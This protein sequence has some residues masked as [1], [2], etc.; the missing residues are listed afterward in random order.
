MLTPPVLKFPDDVRRDLNGHRAGFADEFEQSLV[1]RALPCV[2]VTATRV[3]D[4]PLRRNSVARLFGANAA[5]ALLGPTESKFGGI[6][7]SEVE[8]DWRGYRFLGQINLT[9]A[10]AVLPSR[11]PKLDGL[12][13]IDRSLEG[14]ITD[15]IRVRWFPNI[16]SSRAVHATPESVG[17]W[18]TR[19]GFKLS[20]T[21]PEGNALEALWPL[22]DGPQW[23]YYDRFF[24]AGYNEDGDGA[25][26]Q[27][28]GHKSSGLDDHYGFAPPDGCSN[29]IALYDSLLTLTF[30]NNA[31]FSWGSNWV[32]LIVP[33]DDLARG[34]LRRVVVTGANS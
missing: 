26:H 23:F 18:E 4:R 21:L 25:F 12:L 30:D 19:L 7:Y 3:S 28:L 32:Y 6:P 5:P 20:W 22:K 24:P 31:G 8:E 9:E 34:D 2:A 14:T 11:A 16:D 27:L 17:R 15:C 29:D 10:T 1:A 33:R 13:R